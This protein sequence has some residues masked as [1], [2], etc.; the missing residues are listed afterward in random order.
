MIELWRR[1]TRRKRR[2]PAFLFPWETCRSYYGWYWTVSLID[3]IIQCTSFQSNFLFKFKIILTSIRNVSFTGSP[4]KGLSFFSQSFLFCTKYLHVSTS[5]KPNYC[6]L[7]C[8]VLTLILIL[9]V[10]LWFN[11]TSVSELSTVW[12]K[13]NLYHLRYLNITILICKIE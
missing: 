8:S 4:T 10:I 6:V 9:I 1:D 12:S 3:L 7:L 13:L 11:G 5:C 2:K